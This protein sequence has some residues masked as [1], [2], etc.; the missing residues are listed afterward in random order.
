L[1]YPISILHR[2]LSAASVAVTIAAVIAT[3]SLASPAAAQANAGNC[4]SGLNTATTA[5]GYCSYVG[6]PTW[7]SAFRLVVGCYFY[8]QRV[9]Y[10]VAGRTIYA[11]CPSWSHVTYRYAEPFYG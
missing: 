9:S 5:W 1:S 6:G 2:W 8:P 4:R 11:S 10:G 3:V 7:T